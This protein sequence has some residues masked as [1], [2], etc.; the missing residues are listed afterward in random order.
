MVLP[1][2][3]GPVKELL[4][5]STSLPTFSP[6]PLRVLHQSM[7][8][9]ILREERSA[10]QMT[11]SLTALA[12]APGVLNTAMPCS[13]HL[14]I[15]ILLTPAPARAIARS[16]SENCISCIDAERT[17]MAAGSFALSVQLYFAGSKRSVPHFAILLSVNISV[18]ASPPQLFFSNSF[19]KSTS[20]STPSIGM[21]L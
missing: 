14:S 2:I 6:S 21:A 15:G 5:F 17:I 12:L 8:S 20:C 7:A 11:S 18:M 3:S 19:M 10:A 4:P 9:V 13:E 1:I 16:P